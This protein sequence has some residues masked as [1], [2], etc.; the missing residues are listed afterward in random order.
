[1]D[2]FSLTDIKKMNYSDVYHVIYDNEAMSKQAIAN[3]LQM[4]LPT[5]TQHL[6]A[7]TDS[8]LIQKSGQ[9]KS[10][11][12]RKAAAYS[13]VP[14]AKVA[15]GIEILSERVLIVALDLYGEQIERTHLTETFSATEEYFE[16]IGRAITDFIHSLSISEE[17][18]LGVGFGLQGLVSQDGTE[19][20]YAKILNCTGLKINSFQQYLPFPC[21]FIHDSECAALSDLWNNPEITD[22]IYLSIGNHLGGALIIDGQLS[23]GRTGRSGTFEHMTLVPDGIP[24]YCGQKG[25]MECYCSVGALLNEGENLE[26]FFEE[27]RKENPDILN[28]WD[29]FLSYLAM[30]INNLHM[31]IDC[32]IILGGHIAPYLTEEDITKLHQLVQKNTA[33]PEK[34][35]F[36]LQGRR[37]KHA[38]AIGAALPYILGF[39]NELGT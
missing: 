23:N 27:K 4:S 3:T 29:N 21:R 11:I 24:C 7:L 22:A 5:V 8:G 36:I 25:C 26:G 19:M 2:K 15:I 10:Q 34:E 32:D 18:I 1:M 16:K 14:Q 35:P 20:I 12:G 30:A 17:Q 38:I 31:V 37:K 33:F 6:N 39:L 28:R 13:I 9:L